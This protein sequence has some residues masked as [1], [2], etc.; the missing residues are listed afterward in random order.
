M[1]RSDSNSDSEG[2]SLC[3]TLCFVALMAMFSF[4][5]GVTESVVLS[6]STDAKHE[7]GPA[8]WYCILACCIIH[9][10]SGF[11]TIFSLCQDSE[12]RNKSGAFSLVSIGVAVW[13][14]ICY[15]DTENVCIDLF[16][17]NYNDLWT[18]VF[19]EV[20]IFYIACGILG[21]VVVVAGCYCLGVCCCSRGT[22]L[23]RTSLV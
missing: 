16:K 18:M 17:N 8:I 6:R 10:I 4:G 23:S 5:L 12:K 7:C 21:V 9:F 14:M 20:V 19:I 22:K 15:Y 13:A 11:V 3:C 1:L 2:S